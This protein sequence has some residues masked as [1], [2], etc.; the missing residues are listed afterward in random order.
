[1]GRLRRRGNQDERLRPSPPHRHRSGR[2]DVLILVTITILSRPRHWRGL[3]SFSRAGWALGTYEI[4]AK[5]GL[6]S[7]ARTVA[8]TRALLRKAMEGI[9][10][11]SD[12][13]RKSERR[14]VEPTGFEPATFSLRTRRSTN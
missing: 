3:S 12:F 8:C 9:I 5:P 7:E 6:P 1:M 2:R 11:L 4:Y 10:L 14:M 13:K